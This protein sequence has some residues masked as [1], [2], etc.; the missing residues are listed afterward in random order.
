[1][2][3]D[4]KDPSTHPRFNYRCGPNGNQKKEIVLKDRK[5][6]LKTYIIS[7]DSVVIR[8]RGLGQWLL[9][10]IPA[11]PAA[12]EITSPPTITKV[13]QHL[14]KLGNFDSEALDT[15]YELM[16]YIKEDVL[17]PGSF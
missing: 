8:H 3:L 4:R 1:M 17:D 14:R 7:R 12:S 11:R 2:G 16:G 5:G 13:P 9:N 6:I 15:H 10:R